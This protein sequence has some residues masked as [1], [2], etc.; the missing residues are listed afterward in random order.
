MKTTPKGYLLAL[1]AP[2]MPLLL[3]ATARADT[4]LVADAG[5]N[6]IEKY[7]SVTGA[8]LGIFANTGL[9]SPFAMAFGHSGNLY[10]ANWGDGTIR[11]FSPSGQ[12]LG[13][14]AGASAGVIDPMGLAFDKSDNL[15]A[16]NYHGGPTIDGGIIKIDPAGNGSLFADPGIAR[17]GG[18]A[19]DASEN[20]YVANFDP[21][22]AIY[23]YSPTGTL[24]GIIDGSGLGN[25]SGLAFDSSGYLYA[26][27]YANVIRKFSTDGTD[28]GNFTNV[29]L[30][31][32]LS[33]AFDS[34]GNLY[35]VNY[36]YSNTVQKYDP[37]GNYLGQFA[38]S[39]TTLTSVVV[40]SVPEPSTWA[41]LLAASAL[42][43]LNLRRHRIWT[44]ISGSCLAR[45]PRR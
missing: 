18:I 11:K 12:D 1:A 10:V 37:A 34:A 15:F 43:A 31:S 22:G 30:N 14:F 32:P 4:I 33:I 29:G 36:Y 25:I 3:V 23:Q 39:T 5:S 19:I 35:A 13:V 8:D 20:V 9:N 40:Q 28:L 45:W 38:S 17:L 41:L 16:S 26:A 24:L 2:L 44:S 27:T 42:L 21:G 6:I 7:D